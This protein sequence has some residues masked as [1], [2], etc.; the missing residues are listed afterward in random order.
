MSSLETHG[1][2]RKP[3]DCSPLYD[4]LHGIDL[5]VVDLLQGMP[6]SPVMDG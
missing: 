3:D 6:A 4:L 1:A 2:N 5:A